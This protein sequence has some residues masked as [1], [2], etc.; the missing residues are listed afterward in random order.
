MARRATRRS[1][2]HRF[3]ASWS[4]RTA[5]SRSGATGA[6]ARSPAA[7]VGRAGS[8]R[9]WSTPSTVACFARTALRRCRCATLRP[10]STRR[11]TASTATGALG[12]AAG[13]TARGTVRARLTVTPAAPACSAR[14]TWKRRRPAV[15]R[16]P[17]TAPSQ[18]GPRGTLATGAAGAARPTGSARSW[19]SRQTAERRA[20][21]ISSRR[22]AATRT[23][24]ACRTARS[25]TG[26]S[27]PRA[28]R[29]VAWPSSG[30]AERC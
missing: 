2:R 19:S 5:R 29:P 4:P 11:R 7:A 27:G 3:A 20:P 25:A 24:A 6:S 21:A 12:P 9:C 16:S 28:R 23:P 22:W 17:W 1:R 26:R 10:A 18:S 30:A 14:V 8:A 13:P 15:P